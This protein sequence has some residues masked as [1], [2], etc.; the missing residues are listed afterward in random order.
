MK[1]FRSQR[2]L[3]T[4]LLPVSVTPKSCVLFFFL[5]CFEFVSLVSFALNFVFLIV[6]DLADC[7]MKSLE[8]ADWLWTQGCM[9]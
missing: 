6:S 7:Q 5:F 1:C 3:P 2:E 8:P 9:P 4:V